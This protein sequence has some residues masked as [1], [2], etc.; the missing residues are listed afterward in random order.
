MARYAIGDVQ[1]C[2]NQLI[3]LIDKIGFNPSVDVLYFVGDLVNRGP[4]SYKVLK[5]IYKN[6]DNIICVLG[7]HDIY[8][9]GRYAQILKPD[10][11]ETIGDILNAKDAN[12]L[13]DYLRCQPLVFHDS[14]YI[15]SH[16]GVY[17]KLDFNTL[18]YLNRIISN[19]LQSNDYP[20]FIHKIFG[21]KPTSWSDSLDLIQKMK[22]IINTSTRMRFLNT[23]DYSLDYK[24]KGELA[25]GP[26]ELTPWFK[27]EFDKSI[28]KKI[29][30]GHWAA[31]GFYHDDKVLSLDTGCVWGK[32]LT[33]VNLENFEI[34]Q[35]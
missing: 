4:E 17:P 10:S 26:A 16:A 12:K 5:W 27:V 8:L 35:V 34:F 3:Q 22:F 2:Y 28:N 32:K 11:D 20:F 30:F 24:Y 13:I 19:Y 7:N 23:S 21:N 18:I 9:L 15:L 1:G 29:I 31:L 25:G 6:Q 33:A 14:N